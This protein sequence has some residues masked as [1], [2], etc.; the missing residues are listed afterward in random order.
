VEGARRDFAGTIDATKQPAIEIETDPEAAYEDLAGASRQ[1]R[2]P[3]KINS[4][5]RNGQ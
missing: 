1:E 3:V 4:V 5:A 2:T